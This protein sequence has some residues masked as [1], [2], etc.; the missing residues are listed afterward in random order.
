LGIGANRWAEESNRL[1][2][3]ARVSLGVFW[4]ALGSMC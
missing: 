4:L 1:A 2:L 3:S